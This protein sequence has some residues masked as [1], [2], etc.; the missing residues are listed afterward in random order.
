MTDSPAAFAAALSRATT[1]AAAFDALCT[2]T[3]A[4]VG[5]KLFTIMTVDMGAMLAR[6]A[7]TD[8]PV[9]DPT[10]GTKPIERNAWFD[11][12]HGR[13]KTFVANTL[14]DIA[15]VFPDAELIGRLGCGSVVNLPVVLGGELVATVNILEAEGHYT[16]DRVELI[17]AALAL[18]ALATLAVVRGLA[19]PAPGGVAARA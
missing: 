2:L 11:I 15:R 17:H 10:S 16:P 6:R 3:R 19:A 9:H 4:T 1:E 18:P 5:A 14:A 8:D 13:R 7:Y 12:V